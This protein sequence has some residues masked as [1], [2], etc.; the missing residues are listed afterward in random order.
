MYRHILYLNYLRCKYI[1]IFKMFI[2]FS[3]LYN[4]SE[5]PRFICC[6]KSARMGLGVGGWAWGELRGGVGT[7][8]APLSE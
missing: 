3:L 4:S 1:F 5:K 2:N 6:H 8:E 7:L